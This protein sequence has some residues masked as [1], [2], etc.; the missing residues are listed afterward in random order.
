MVPG[1]QNKGEEREFVQA[2]YFQFDASRVGRGRVWMIDPH[3]QS[4]N[5][6]SFDGI[7]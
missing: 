1:S 3:L 7:Q 5:A 2:F 6:D 4:A